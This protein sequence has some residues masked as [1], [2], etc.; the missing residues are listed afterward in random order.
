MQFFGC[1]NSC[2]WSH[3]R[4]QTR[5]CGLG[6]TARPFASLQELRDTVRAR[7]ADLH[8]ASVSPS[9]PE[10]PS[11]A[12][13]TPTGLR[14]SNRDPQRNPKPVDR[15]EVILPPDV[16]LQPEPKD[17]QPWITYRAPKRR[18]HTPIGTGKDREHV[19]QK[20]GE[21]RH[22][23]SQKK[24]LAAS[25]SAGV[26][27]GVDD[28]KVTPAQTLLSPA[29]EKI[30]VKGAARGQPQQIQGHLLLSRQTKSRAKFAKLVQ[31]SCGSSPVVAMPEPMLTAAPQTFKVALQIRAAR[32][33][34]AD[35]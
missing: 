3:C 28:N 10:Q 29:E 21:D 27:S 33:S 34:D 30:R 2:S 13:P 7:I 9:T 23:A 11:T 16:E 25:N 8:S 17:P 22:P 4:C 12:P 15:E 20:L 14:D 6:D 26:R 1:L 35:Y 19:G 32:G 24:S 5:Y 31:A 18:P